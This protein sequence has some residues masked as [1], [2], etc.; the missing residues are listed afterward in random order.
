[1]PGGRPTIDLQ[2][3]AAIAD[4]PLLLEASSAAED[5]GY[6][7]LWVFDHLAGRSLR[8]TTML[9]CFTW[10]GALAASTRT[11]GLGSLVANVW[12]RE[13][14]VLA[15]AAASVAH[16]AA[17]RPVFVGLGA[18]T[19][20]TSSF[21]VEQVAVGARIEPALLDR[22]RRVA[23]TLDLLDAMWADDRDERF[24]T[25]PLPRPRPVTVV[26]VNSVALAAL[27]GARADGINVRWGDARAAE[28]IAAARR[29]RS[30]D[31]PPL[32]VTAY[33]LWDD[34]LFDADA[35]PRRALDALGVDRVI[36]T[37]LDRPDPARIA[38]ALR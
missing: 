15:V 16:I 34:L 2:L 5:A 12:N 33:A 30:D 25:F 6:G 11:I 20:P 23:A 1:V 36:M 26:G 21:A 4:W 9:E 10:L 38:D 22:H 31:A 28:L 37:V 13:P 8:G 18:G 24:E 27:A 35:P 17:G 29:A 19:S 3:N 7:A 14:G 32:L